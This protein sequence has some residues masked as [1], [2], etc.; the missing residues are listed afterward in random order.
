ASAP[1]LSRRISLSSSTT[2]MRLDAFVWLRV[3]EGTAWPPRASKRLFMFSVFALRPACLQCAFI[4]RGAQ[5]PPTFPVLSGYASAKAFR[6]GLIPFKKLYDA[7][8]FQK[9][10]CAH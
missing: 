9:Q 8:V 2:R 5:A 1:A 3:G 10:Q 7:V 6:S 4:Q